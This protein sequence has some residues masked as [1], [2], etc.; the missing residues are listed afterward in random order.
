MP[1]KMVR[2]FGTGE[3]F[4][5]RIGVDAG[6]IVERHRVHQSISPE[7]RAATRVAAF[8]IGVNTTSSTLPVGLSHQFGLRFQ[9]VF[10]PGS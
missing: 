4:G 2:D 7:S 3:H 5:R 6:L 9:T 8:G 10:T 1:R